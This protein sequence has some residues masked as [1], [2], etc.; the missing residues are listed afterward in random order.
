MRTS[1][2][3]IAALAALLS[4][5]VPARGA[6]P[7]AIAVD[8]A[9][10][11]P[12]FQGWGVSLAWWANV[13]GGYAEPARSRLMDELFDPK[14]GLGLNAVRYNIGGGENPDRHTLQF[15]AALPGYEP[16]PG[17][18][19]WSADANQRWVL[20]AAVRR[21]ADRLQA[22][23]NSPPWWMTRSG[24]VAGGVDGGENLRADSF[25]SFAD[26]LVAVARKFHD[27]W[28]I[29]FDTLEPFNEPSSPWWRAG[30]WQEGC[31]FDR[32]A[33]DRLVRLVGERLR[34]SGLTTKVAAADENSIDE[35]LATFNGFSFE[36]R[37]FTS[38]V[39][40]HGYNGSH[41]A[42]LRKA[43]GADGKP[44]W[45]SEYGDDDPSGLTLAS[46]IV[47]DLRGLHPAGWIAWQAAD[48]ANG[49]G[50]FRS[51]LDTEADP[52]WTRNPKFD[53]LRNFAN[54]VRPG[55]R[56]IEIADPHAIAAVDR[57]LDTLVIV[58]VNAGTG[59]A[60]RTYDLVR[61]SML[62]KQA[63][64]WRTSATER[65][66]TVSPIAVL[67]GWL[68]VTLAAR[69]VTTFELSNTAFRGPQPAVNPD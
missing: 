48:P 63:R 30:G 49:W 9:R 28:H 39:A 67:N 26:Y 31:R 24:T 35:A 12:P 56:L 33:Q 22:F 3:A 1:A 23:S 58:A 61:F 34:A 53:V 50:L 16:S 54:H 10:A 45:M 64:T 62:G 41:R 52:R 60:D 4:L 6:D 55:D 21:G 44:I 27:E 19:D 11:D 68:S 13:A 7:P 38:T 29:T 5:S 17:R 57:R 32:P 59:P 46:Q 47:A 43:A 69:S 20:A 37:S 66:A 2:R 51:R 65:H 25:E 36:A 42:A 14:L 18:W 8:P 15:R 40:T